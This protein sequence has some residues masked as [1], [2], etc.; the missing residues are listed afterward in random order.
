MSA[1]PRLDQVFPALDLPADFD[2]D[3]FLVS[4]GLRSL[5]KIEEVTDRKLDSTCNSVEKRGLHTRAISGPGKG[6]SDVFFARN[7]RALERVHSLER[8][9]RLKRNAARRARACRTIGLALG[10]PSCCVEAFIASARQN[11]EERLLSFSRDLSTPIDARLNFF[12]RVFAPTS[13]LP[14]K[15]ECKASIRRADKVLEEIGEQLDVDPQ[16]ILEALEGII[17]WT[18]GPHFLFFRG[19]NLLDDTS[20]TYNEVYG[21]HEIMELPPISRHRK[22]AK[23]MDGL[24]EQL[25]N[26]NR[27]SLTETGAVVYSEDDVVFQ[28]N[29]TNLRDHLLRFAKMD[30]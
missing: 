29:Q 1:E 17:A 5:G 30:E 22:A 26:G 10:Y 23:E 9:Q 20:F 12:P 19:V 21:S 25:R 15:P 6:M 11:D 16:N 28:W 18:S 3:I 27:L 13:H 8:N 24:L 7:H 14:C 2:M 4:V